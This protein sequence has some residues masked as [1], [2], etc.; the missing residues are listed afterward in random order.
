MFLLFRVESTFICDDE[1]DVVG[2][3]IRWLAFPA[4]FLP[5]FNATKPKFIR[6]PHL[7]VVESI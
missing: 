1:K 4:L 3:M 6:N 2:V 7:F 5:I